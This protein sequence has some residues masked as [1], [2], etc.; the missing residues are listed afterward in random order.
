MGEVLT[1]TKAR[2]GIISPRSYLRLKRY[3]N[4]ATQRSACAPSGVSDAGTLWR[5]RQGRLA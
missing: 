1:A 5:V 4:L 2:R 3:S